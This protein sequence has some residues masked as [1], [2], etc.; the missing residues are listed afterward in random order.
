[1]SENKTEK[2]ETKTVSAKVDLELWYRVLDKAFLEIHDVKASK[3]I[4]LALEAY[5][6]PT[7]FPRSTTHHTQS[8]PR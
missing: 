3:I 1:M 6:S 5:V 7:K 8:V 4:P 2:T